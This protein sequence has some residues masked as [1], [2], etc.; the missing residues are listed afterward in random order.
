MDAPTNLSFV[1]QLNPERRLQSSK[2][3][4]EAP[5]T[6]QKWG[7]LSVACLWAVPGT[8]ELEWVQGPAHPTQHVGAAAALCGRTL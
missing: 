7:G 8:R 5:E 1:T 3:V 6:S 4:S 2:L